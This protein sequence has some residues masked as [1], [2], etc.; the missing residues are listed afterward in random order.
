MKIANKAFKKATAA[1]KRIMIAKDVIAALKAKQYTARF[2]SFCDLDDDDSYKYEEE[3]ESV[4]LD[5]QEYIGEGG[6]CYVCALGGLFA[7]AVRFSNSVDYTIDF[8]YDAEV[9]PK[10]RKF[11]SDKQIK[12]MELAFEGGAGHYSF[13]GMAEK[14]ED[15]IL[16][17]R[18]DYEDSDN[19]VLMTAIM[20][21][22]VK[23]G[24][25]FKL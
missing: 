16:D 2:G 19:S 23:N 21:N 18:R 15:A 24:G 4:D 9:Y 25:Q 5:A 22:V 17:F 1:E 14:E 13:S 3:K 10:L 11:F 12:I 20:K 7:S 8:D 6:G